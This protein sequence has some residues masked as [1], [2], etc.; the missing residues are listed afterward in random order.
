[1]ED[2]VFSCSGVIT[3]WTAYVHPRQLGERRESNQIAFQVWRVG[4]NLP[5][6]SPQ[7]YTLIGVNAYPTAL[8]EENVFQVTVDVE[9]RIR[10]QAGDVAGYAIRYG[11][12]QRAPALSHFSLLQ[13]QR[14]YDDCV[15][16]LASFTRIGQPV[17]TATL[18]MYMYTQALLCTCMYMYSQ[19]LLCMYMYAQALLRMY[20]TLAPTCK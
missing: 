16:P 2:Y 12:F 19:A 5:E 1:M 17:F 6:E 15:V 13:F 9:K 20:I 7:C 18:G 3:A 11:D 10:V 4:A 8:V 14:E